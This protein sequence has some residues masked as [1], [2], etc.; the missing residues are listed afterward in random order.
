[1][2]FPLFMGI[3]TRMAKS[4]E[5]LPAGWL[6]PRQAI[7]KKEMEETAR[8]RWAV[9]QETNN[10][11]R[12]IYDALPDTLKPPPEIQALA[13]SLLRKDML[14]HDTRVSWS[15]RPPRK[16]KSCSRRGS[17]H[18]TFTPPY[19][20]DFSPFVSSGDPAIVQLSADHNA[21]QINYDVFPNQQG[22]PSSLDA[23]AG[24]GVFFSLPEGQESPD[25]LTLSANVSFNFFW[26]AEGFFD[27]ALTTNT[28]SLVL[29]L[30]EFLN[31]GTFEGL[32]ISQPTVLWSFSESQWWPWSNQNTG[33]GSGFSPQSGAAQ[34]DDE[35]FYN[36]WV[37]FNGTFQCD[38][39]T[40]ATGFATVTVDS[41]T[42]DLD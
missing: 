8:R 24:V 17:F 34:I 21:G 39:G 1:M 37:F 32:A 33:G 10:K 2:A 13:A 12:K 9:Q 16:V 41:I 27:A 5:S 4:K 23:W 11:L 19:D 20:F 42:V 35:H 26:Q 38:G 7:F 22:Q 6:A 28:G 3:V 18:Q 31:V 40:G 25:T 29:N 15:Q 14:R 36:A 30:D